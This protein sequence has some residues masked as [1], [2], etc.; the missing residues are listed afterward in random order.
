MT[1]T[2]FRTEDGLTL[3][4]DLREPEGAPR[5]TAVICHPHPEH[6][7]SK[8]HPLL[9][10]IRNELAK[11]GWLVLSFNFRGVMGS[12]GEHTGGEKET[13]DVKAAIDRVRGEADGPTVLVGWSFGAN[14]AI[15]H[16]MTDPRVVA[17]A[18]VGLPLGFDPVPVVELP[19]DEALRAWDVP[20]LLVTGDDDAICPVPE[21]LE[22]SGRIPN[23]DVRVL[24]GAGHF[25]RRREREPAEAV[26]DFFDEVLQ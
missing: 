13:E 26:A 17:V 16:A 15:R 21:V 24:E 22:L 18:L 19:D 3:E 9:W 25:F 10:A 8:D 23:A 4:G 6:G 2:T 7:G 20:V 14:V 1:A 11:R 5:G 12:E